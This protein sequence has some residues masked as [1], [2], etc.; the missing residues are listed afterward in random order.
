[1]SKADST[2]RK[3]RGA[4]DGIGLVHKAGDYGQAL[5]ASIVPLPWL[6]RREKRT[7]YAEHSSVWDSSISTREILARP[8][9]T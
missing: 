8:L 9:S 1:M 6:K 3:A 5:D 4:F 2:Y 7:F